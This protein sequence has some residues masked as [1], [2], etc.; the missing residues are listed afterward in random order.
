MEVIDSVNILGVNVSRIDLQNTI[1]CISE[2]IEAGDKRRICVAPVNCILAVAQEERLRKIYN[3][4]DLVLPDGVP[5]IWASY[6]LR[7]PIPG[8]VTGLDL[9]PAFIE[10]AATKGHTNYFLGASKGVACR[11]AQKLNEKFKGLKIV[12]YYSPPFYKKFPEKENRKIV[13][14]VNSVNPD[15]LWVSLTAPKQDIWIYE[16]L[17]KLNVKIAIGVGGAFEVTAGIIPRAPIWMQK[18]GL[19]WF[20]RFLKEPRRLF[21]RYFIE[22]PKFIPLVLRQMMHERIS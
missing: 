5:L 7:K 10:L 13:Q 8:R 22:A 15:V 21:R 6:L 11:L 20:Y 9:L 3:T 17:D 18:S 16:N 4:A 19:E 12:G 1:K 14:M 2:W